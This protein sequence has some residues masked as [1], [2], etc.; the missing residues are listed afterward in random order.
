MCD[1]VKTLLECVGEDPNREGLLKTPMRY[2]KALMFFTKG[3][4]DNADG[5]TLVN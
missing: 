1:A 3:Y 4:E 2:A 5:K